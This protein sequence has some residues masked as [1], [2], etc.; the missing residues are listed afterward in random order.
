MCSF[1]LDFYATI[2]SKN[3]MYLTGKQYRQ[4][5]GDPYIPQYPYIPQ[6]ADHSNTS[7]V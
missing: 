5:S 6:M 7:R 4:N 1:I 2:F 3:R